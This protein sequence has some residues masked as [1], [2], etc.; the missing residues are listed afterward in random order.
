VIFQAL[1]LLAGLGTAPQPLADTTQPYVLSADNMKIQQLGDDKITWLYGQVEIIH[2]STILKGDTARISTLT[3]KASVWGRVTI[4]DKT[5]KITGRRADYLKP[6]GRA[7][8]FGRPRLND[9]GWDLT[10]DSLAYSRP[11]AKSY[12]YG[13]VEMI[14]SSQHN[15]LYGDYGEYWHDQGYGFV[16]GRARMESY[17]KKNRTKKSVI[18]SNKMEVFQASGLAVATD[19]V[20][21]AQDSLWA[22]CGKM[23]YFKTAG[24]M[25]LEQ[26]PSV[27]RR[28]ALISG[29]LM[30]LDLRGDTLRNAWVRDSA[31]VRQF[32]E[33]SPDTDIITCDSLKADFDQGQM[34]YV[35]AWG[36]VWCQYHRRQKENSSGR[37]LAQ[38]Q[39]MEFF[40]SQGKTQ[41]ILMNKKAKG[42]YHSREDVK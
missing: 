7:S 13:Q 38:G 6:T 35:H 26:E 28:D 25:M 33:A 41:R 4:Y 24:R 12:A 17:D 23:T 1:L 40:M 27:W 2:G 11:L 18:T 34:S 5:V 29:R 42:A 21:F 39:E 31:M 16:I 20:R 30:E 10:A 14:D 8:V 9:A 32:T 15:K 36:R 19:S 37:N 22:A 3:E